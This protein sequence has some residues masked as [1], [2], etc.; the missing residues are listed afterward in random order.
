MYQHPVVAL[1]TEIERLW[2]DSAEQ[3]AIRAEVVAQ[4]LHS[5]GIVDGLVV[6]GRLCVS[7]HPRNAVNGGCN[8]AIKID[9]SISDAQLRKM[10]AQAELAEL[11]VN[12]FSAKRS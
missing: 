5:A 7:E 1:L 9:G 11:R 3:A 10:A 12:E 8:V 6:D 2:S 4:R